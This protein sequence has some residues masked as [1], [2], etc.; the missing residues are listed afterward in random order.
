M[1]RIDFLFA[2]FLWLGLTFANSAFAVTTFSVGTGAVTSIDRNATFDNIVTDNSLLGY[3]E[4]GIIISVDDFAFVDTYFAV[5]PA[6]DGGLHYGTSGNSDYVSI[7]TT[8]EVDIY[9]IVMGLGDG[10]GAN[11]PLNIT[12]E[13]WKNGVKIGG[14][15]N[16]NLVGGQYYGFRDNNGFDELRIAAFNQA[17]GILGT[18][19]AIAIDDVRLQLTPS[20]PVPGAIWL[21]GSGVI[22]MVGFRRKYCC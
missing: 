11:N 10:W 13:T 3:M 17:D 4:D 5:G 14:M 7:K 15:S 1:K 2:C 22:C 21:L 16:N 19:Q 9:S 20:V 18:F 8:D 12:W 6:F